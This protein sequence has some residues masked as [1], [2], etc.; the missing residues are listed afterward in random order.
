M[1][2]LKMKMFAV[3]VMFLCCSSMAVAQ[4]LF[5]ELSE[6]EK[7]MYKSLKG[8]RDFVRVE[9]DKS[10]K[11]NPSKTKAVKAMLESKYAG[12]YLVFTFDEY[13]DEFKLGKSINSVRGKIRIDEE[14]LVLIGKDDK[15]ILRAK[16]YFLD[17][18]K[19][20]GLSYKEDGVSVNLIFEK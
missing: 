6:D 4:K 12:K 17:V 19:T 20:L 3:L 13:G 16:I 8:H 10:N 7:M 9:I 5:A 2:N 14:D 11:A 15:L 18:D 1:K